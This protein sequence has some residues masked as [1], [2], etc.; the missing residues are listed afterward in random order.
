MTEHKYTF[1]IPARLTVELSAAN[2]EE[3]REFLQ[4]KISNAHGL[5]AELRGA[6]NTRAALL[7]CPLPKNHRLMR[8]DGQYTQTALEAQGFVVWEHPLA[9]G[10]HDVPE[11]RQ[12]EDRK[13]EHKR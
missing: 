1:S 12:A 7:G 8:V 6:S 4:D 13:D 5:Y 3:A 2:E 11:R 9:P 10:S